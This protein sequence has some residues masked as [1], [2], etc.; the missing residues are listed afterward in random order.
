M[1]ATLAA[2]SINSGRQGE[3]PW[4]RID[5]LDG[6]EGLAQARPGA[7][8]PPRSP[9]APYRATGL[10]GLLQTLPA[11]YVQTASQKGQNT[12]QFPLRAPQN[13]E[14]PLPATR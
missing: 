2:I 11:R 8:S 10:Q 7:H 3:A 12:A 5:P 13:W 6:R 14:R 4:D 9:P 1:S